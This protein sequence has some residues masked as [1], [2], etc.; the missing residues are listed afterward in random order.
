MET[1]NNS[2]AECLVAT[3][4]EERGTRLFKSNCRYI[5]RTDITIAEWTNNI[6]KNKIVNRIWDLFLGFVVWEIQKTQNLK[7]FENKRHQVEEIWANLVA[8]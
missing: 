3:M 1:I 6:Y 2:L 7:N 8:H 5:R 4:I